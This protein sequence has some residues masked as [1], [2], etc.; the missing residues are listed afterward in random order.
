MG[1][2]AA[3]G[4]GL[5]NT[6]SSM[7]TIQR[8]VMDDLDFLVEID[9]LGDGY[10]SDPDEPPMS[11]T[12]LAQH[13][14]KIASFVRQE[15]DLAWVVLDEAG[16]RVGAILARYRDR[17][18]EPPNEA[19]LFLFRFLDEAL[20]PADGRFCEV[21]NLWVHPAHRRQGLAMR[22][23]QVIEEE[24]RRRGMKMI[25]THTEAA[26]LHV[27]EMNRKLG[28]QEVRCGPI[29]DAVPRVSLIKWLDQPE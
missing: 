22:L 18:H 29:W 3:R 28:Y 25:Y 20:F 21:F 12:D 2:F 17:L 23:K 7:Y 8:A 15:N 14:E 4:F 24:A 11:E 10:T 27:I 6:I 26:N 19:N 16:Q 13:R 9:L 5:C 1:G